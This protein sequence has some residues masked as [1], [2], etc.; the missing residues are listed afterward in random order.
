MQG[1]PKLD[2]E[3]SRIEVEVTESPEFKVKTTY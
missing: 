3:L 1:A 2:E